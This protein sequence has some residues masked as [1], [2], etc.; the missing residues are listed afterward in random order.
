MR[1]SKL[2]LS[3][4]PLACAFVAGATAVAFVADANAAEPQQTSAGV[5]EEIVVTSRREEE[6]IQD[7]PVAVSA[8]TQQDITRLAPYTL[9]DMDGLMPNVSIQQ[10]TAGPSMGAIYIRGIGSAD[11]EKTTPP[12]VGIVVDGIFMATNTVS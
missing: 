1:V 3:M 2:L 12:Q 11:V 7:V 6:Q 5:I 4:A 10:Q 9:A 8:F